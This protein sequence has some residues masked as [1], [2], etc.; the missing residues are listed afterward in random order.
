MA[1]RGL[2]IPCVDLVVNF[3]IPTNSKDYIHRV[4]RTARAGKSGRAITIVTQY[5]IEILQ[6][7]ETLLGCKLEEYKDLDM[8]A[9]LVLT[10]SVVEASRI[11]NMELRQR[12]KGGKDSDDEDNAEANSGSKAFGK[13]RNHSQ[14]HNKGFGKGA[15]FA[16]KRPRKQ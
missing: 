15:S 12:E 3:D 5:D 14:M 9:A 13:K 2:D 6:K 7:I 11:A 4:G 8:K 16:K 10:D 1:S